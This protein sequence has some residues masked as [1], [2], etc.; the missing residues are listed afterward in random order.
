M[1]QFKLLI[2]DDEIRFA[3]ML[4]KRLQLRGCDC[5]VCYNGKEAL[6]LVNQETFFLILLDLHLPDIYG[7]EVLAK[8]KEIDPAVPVIVLTG[9]GNEKDRQACLSLGA[10]AFLHKPLGIDDFISMLN[11]IRESPE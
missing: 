1:K 4:A 2:V 8:I 11:T 9:H 5:R 3:N 10:Y 7:V 6:R